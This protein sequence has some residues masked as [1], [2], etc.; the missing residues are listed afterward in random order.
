VGSRYSHGKTHEANATPQGDGCPNRAESHPL[1]I[2]VTEK[3]IGFLE[4]H[5][6]EC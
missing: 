6:P 2:Q 3:L 4:V 5:Y 1:T